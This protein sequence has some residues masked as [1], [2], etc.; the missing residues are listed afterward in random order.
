[1]CKAMH[2]HQMQGCMIPYLRMLCKKSPQKKG[3]M[4]L[5]LA[6]RSDTNMLMK[7]NPWLDKEDKI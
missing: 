3:D 6:I 1:M 4:P 2:T 5:Y 7:E